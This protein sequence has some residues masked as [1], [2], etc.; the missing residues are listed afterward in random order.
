MFVSIL[1]LLTQVRDYPS[2]RFKARMSGRPMSAR[3]ATRADFCRA[4][5]HDTSS[6][7][8]LSL[9]LTASPDSAEECFVSS[10]ADI[11]LK[12]AVLKE[13]VHSYTRR[14]VVQRAVRML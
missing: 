6:L 13:W 4:F 5:A 9:L 10:L 3:Y 1:F 7:Y 2:M 12:T 11:P 8:L 14:I